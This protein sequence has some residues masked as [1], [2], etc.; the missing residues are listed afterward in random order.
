MRANKVD[1]DL[2]LFIRFIN[3]LKSRLSNPYFRSLHDLPKDPAEDK[4]NPEGSKKGNE[5]ASISR[6]K[7]AKTSFRG[8]AA[9]VERSE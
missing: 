6:A 1:P 3:D 5:N 2:G 8:A 9:K 7:G 4:P